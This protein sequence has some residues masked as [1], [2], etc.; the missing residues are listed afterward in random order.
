M[1]FETRD[2]RVGA[3]SETVPES[4]VVDGTQLT[5]P[6]FSSAPTVPPSPR[7]LDVV[8]PDT[9]PEIATPVCRSPEESGAESRR[10]R[11]SQGESPST[12]FGVRCAY[13][14]SGTRDEL[15]TPYNVLSF[16]EDVTTAEISRV[17]KDMREECSMHGPDGKPALPVVAPSP[18]QPAP[19][20]AVPTLPIIAAPALQCRPPIPPAELSNALKAHLL[21][22]GRSAVELRGGQVVLK[23]KNAKRAISFDDE[24][25]H[26]SLVHVGNKS[27]RFGVSDV[28]LDSAVDRSLA[29]AEKCV[30]LMIED[31]LT[32][33]VYALA[34]KKS[35][36]KAKEQVRAAQTDAVQACGDVLQFVERHHIAAVSEDADQM[37]SPL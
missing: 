27:R 22:S 3:A 21:R 35:L 9:A 33:L 32:A 29:M 1:V 23:D 30:E 4:E 17:R 18:S 24:P 20:P 19:T 37:T 36:G 12:H 13:V 26:S 28:S 7:L 34:K 16:H 25:G 2:G 6:S 14:E 10:P 11:P 5:S 31:I 8:V 15:E